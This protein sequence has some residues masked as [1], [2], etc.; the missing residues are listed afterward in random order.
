MGDDLET[1]CGRIALI[2]GEKV[3]ITILESEVAADNEKGER[4]LVGIIGDE[5][6][7]NKDAFRN[8]LSCIWRTVG[9]VVFK[10][11]QGNVWLLEFADLG[12]KKRVMGG[13]P[14]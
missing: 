8:I 11:V 10:E 2:G 9:L 3:G 5:K 4:C 14:W 13:R 12:D 7:V 6:K 1:L